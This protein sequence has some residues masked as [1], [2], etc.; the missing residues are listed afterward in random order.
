MLPNSLTLDGTVFDKTV[1]RAT[2]STYSVAASPLENPI[3]LN[4]SHEKL[5]SGRINSVVVLTDDKV[6]PCD[7]SACLT[8][9]A[10]SP[11]RTQFKVSYNPTQG[12]TDIMAAL[13]KQYTE[14][15]IFLADPNNWAAFINQ[16][17]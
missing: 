4:V 9:V 1:Q 12:R 10:M 17:S 16:E 5:K 14:I 2:S 11:V 13:E 8:T 6:I 3:T 7:A 15:S